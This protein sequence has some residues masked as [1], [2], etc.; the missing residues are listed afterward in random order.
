[1]VMNVKPI[2]TLDDRINDI[3]M[4]TAEIVN[5]A[6]VPNEA[7]LW[8]LQPAGMTSLNT[9][10]ARRSNSGKRSSSGCGRLACGHRTCRKSTGGWDGAFLPRARVHERGARLRPRGIRA[11][12]RRGTELGQL[13]DP[14]QVRDRGAEA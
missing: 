7:K 3:R 1:M 4:R 13:Q 14:A 5:D 2:P 12:R 9:S 8:N 10:V 11:L 6:I